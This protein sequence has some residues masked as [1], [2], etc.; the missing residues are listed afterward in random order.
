MKPLSDSWLTDGILDVEYK[1]YILLSYLQEIR[2]DYLEWK[3]YPALAD[4]IRHYANLHDFLNKK[5]DLEKSFRQTLRQINPETL[6]LQYSPEI[7]PEE[8]MQQI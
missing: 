2:K 7:T 1:Q 3:L 5:T 6:Q 4:V 8:W